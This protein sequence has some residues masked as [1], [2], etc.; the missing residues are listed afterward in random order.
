MSKLFALI[1]LVAAAASANELSYK[2]LQSGP[3]G[4][5]TPIFDHGIHGEGQIIAFLDTGV[6][7]DI[8]FFVEPNGSRP[9]INTR[10]DQNNVDLTRRKI[11]AYDFLYSCDQ[12]P[13]AAG[14]DDPNSPSGWDNHGHGTHAAA[15][16]GGDRAT[17]IAHDY[18][19]SIAP[20]AELIVA[21]G[22]YVGG[23]HCA[24][25]AGSGRPVR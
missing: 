25:R 9:P 8:C 24:P 6:D 15:S 4:S 18:G 2:T 3:S 7:Y 17:P 11:V 12:F 10:F 14:C 21:D 20:R 23:A 22:R 19:D 5:T 1:S 13:G 16:A